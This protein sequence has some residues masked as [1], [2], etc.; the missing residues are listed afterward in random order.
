MAHA[1]DNWPPHGILAVA[2]EKMPLRHPQ[3]RGAASE[4]VTGTYVS[5]WLAHV[6]RFLLVRAAPD[7]SAEVALP[8]VMPI[9][10]RAMAH[11]GI[12]AALLVLSS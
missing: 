7:L 4:Y 8:P 5:R 10:L 9:I 11:H 2:Q 6:G 3:W 1:P 12:A